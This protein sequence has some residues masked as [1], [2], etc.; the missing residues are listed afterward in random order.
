MR[1]FVAGA[2]GVIGRQLVPQLVDAGHAV[3]GSTRSGGKAGWLADAGAAPAVLDPLDRAQVMTAVMRAEPD[4]VIH[5]LTALSGQ[6]D[7]RRFDRSFAE[8][9][10]L[11]TRGLDILLEA[12]RAAGATR[13]LA[14]SYTGWPNAREGGPVKTEDDPL[15]PHPPRAMRESIAAIRSLEEA[16]TGAEGMA[17][18]ALRYGSLYGPGTSMSE[19]YTALI[20]RRK[21]P[22]VGDGAAVWSFIH[23]ADAAAATVAALDHGAPGVYN[24]VDDEPA[25]VSEWLPEL[26]AILGAKPPRHIPAW[27]GRL[28]TGQVGVAM[29]T[30]SRGSSNAKARR[31][32]RWEPAHPSWRTGFAETA[33]GAPRGVRSGR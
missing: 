16:V 6:A 14:Q 24:I 7:L 25:P 20:R 32:L 30:Q 27:I 28:A 29:M 13:F 9:N 5:E 1:V 26:A 18:L 3:V 22:V 31:E 12:A 21:F 19:E 15:D 33:G 17:G 8:T 10:V 4:A 23:V 2:T 11:R